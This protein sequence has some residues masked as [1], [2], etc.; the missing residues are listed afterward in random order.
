[1]GQ[2]LTQT[3]F[4]STTSSSN[5][6]GGDQNRTAELFEVGQKVQVVSFA[7]LTTKAEAATETLKE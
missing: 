4:S 1:M 5:D 7:S 2:T 3:V 6:N